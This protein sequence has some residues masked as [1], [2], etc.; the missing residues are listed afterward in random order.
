MC[1]DTP[2]RGGAPGGHRLV[3]PRR[4]AA[5]GWFGCWCPAAQPAAR[6]VD[7]VYRYDSSSREACLEDAKGLA[8]AAAVRAGADPDAVRI[9]AVA[10]IPMSYVPGGGCRVQVKAAGPLAAA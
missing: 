8:I 7:R 9:T 5:V 4:C 1:R 3:P 10:E 2:V 6:R